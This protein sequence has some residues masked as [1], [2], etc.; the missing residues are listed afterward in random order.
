MRNES[1]ALLFGATSII[2]YTLARRFAPCVTPVV[3]PH[4][5]AHAASAWRRVGVEDA[6]LLSGVLSLRPLPLVVYCHAVCDIA[7]C[8]VNPQWAEALNV[9]SVATLLDLLPAETRLVYV[10]SDHV[11]GGNGLYAEDAAPCPISVY[12]HTR[13]EAERYVRA[14]PRSLV[15]RVGLP[16]GP[17][18]NGRTGHLD[19]LRYR[20]RRGLPITIVR[21]EYRSVVWAEDLAERVMT[22]ARSEVCGLRHVP[23]RRALGRPELAT[24]LMQRQ[25]LLPTFTLQSRAEQAVP[26]LGHVE[27]V[28]RY[29]DVYGMPLRSVVDEEAPPGYQEPAGLG[30]PQR[31][32]GAPAI[33]LTPAA[34]PMS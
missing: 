11:F 31:P 27:L 20:S 8:E 10:S 26:H 34:G 22:L 15:I 28:S 25:G 24:Y 12:G 9:G 16:I 1:P 13:I 4:T 17:S 23:A 32:I 30:S 21:D 2:G 5:V 14:R 3:N 6:A 18:I 7:K 19:W 29:A 33:A